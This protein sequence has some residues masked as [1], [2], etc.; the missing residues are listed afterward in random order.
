MA[1]TSATL[2]TST[3]SRVSPSAATAL[4]RGRPWPTS[5]SA[6]ELTVCGFQDSFTI[7][8]AH[9]WLTRSTSVFLQ[10]KEDQAEP[11]RVLGDWGRR[12]GTAADVRER[13]QPPLLPQ[14]QLHAP[15]A[16]GD[17]FGQRGWARSR[18]A[19]R[20]DGHG[21]EPASRSVGTPAYLTVQSECSDF[22]SPCSNWT[23]SQTS[24]RG[25]KRWWSC[26]TCTWWRTGGFLLMFFCSVLCLLA[27]SEAFQFIYFF[28]KITAIFQPCL[29]HHSFQAQW[30]FKINVR[31]VCWCDDVFSRHF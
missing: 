24:M 30:T 20:E 5:W 10:A 12:A 23:S 15:A 9:G 19:Q 22:F 14:W 26:G 17:G 3:A 29:W 7:L 16:S 28:Y 21:E 18:M 11:L 4:W 31:H 8:A 13:T 27:L 2:R 6:G 25:R 1:R